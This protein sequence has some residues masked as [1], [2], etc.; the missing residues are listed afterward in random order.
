MLRSKSSYIEKVLN[1]WAIIL[2]VWSVY[3]ATFK[4][5][6]PIWFDEFL[7]KPLIFLIPIYSFIK[8]NEKTNFFT[9]VGLKKKGLWKEILIGLLLGAV[10]FAAGAFGYV[11]KQ[12]ADFT[13]WV[14]VA[15]S[16]N[17]LY[18]LLI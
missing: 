7:A 10:F 15:M 11:I 6:L 3:R 4:T 17:L 2:I 5:D 1:V 13:A 16:K 12:N 9:S 18:F 8:K 14:S